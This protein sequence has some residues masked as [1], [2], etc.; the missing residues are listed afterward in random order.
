MAQIF[1]GKRGFKFVKIKKNAPFQ[2]EIIAKIVK[3][4]SIFKE[5]KNLLYNQ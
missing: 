3:L 4:H 1:L 5:K 2:R